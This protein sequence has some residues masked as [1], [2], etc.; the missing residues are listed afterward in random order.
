MLETGDKV[1]VNIEGVPY[2]GMIE[3]IYDNPATKQTTYTVEISRM[4]THGIYLLEE[5]TPYAHS[6]I[7]NSF[8]KVQNERN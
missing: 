7:T 2:V 8:S 5:L 1:T 3:S 4:G 6:H